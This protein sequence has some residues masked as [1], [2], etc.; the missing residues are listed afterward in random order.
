MRVIIEEVTRFMSEDPP[1]KIRRLIGGRQGWQILL[2]GMTFLHGVD[3][4]IEE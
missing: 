4:K 1:S 2:L 3:G